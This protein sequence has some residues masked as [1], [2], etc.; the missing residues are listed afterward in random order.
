MLC[1]AP[2]LAVA[3]FHATDGFDYGNPGHKM[4]RNAKTSGFNGVLGCAVVNAAAEMSRHLTQGAGPQVWLSNKKPLPAWNSFKNTHESLLVVEK[5]P[6]TKV[7][8]DCETFM[9]GKIRKISGKGEWATVCAQ[10]LISSLSLGFLLLAHL[11]VCSVCCGSQ[12][13]PVWHYWQHAQHIQKCM[14]C[15]EFTGWEFI[16]GWPACFTFHQYSLGGM[17]LVGLF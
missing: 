17:G 11:A 4:T 10:L 5:K 12:Q 15:E 8:P 7:Y 14:W 3:N 9:W 1:F 13:S 2:K 16:K 6:K